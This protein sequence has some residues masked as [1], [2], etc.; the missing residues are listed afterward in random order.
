MIKA[1]G[2]TDRLAWVGGECAFWSFLSK[3]TMDSW[4]G[5]YRFPPFRTER[6]K[7]GAPKSYV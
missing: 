3:E 1:G 6:G 7:G 2:G 4:N 5:R